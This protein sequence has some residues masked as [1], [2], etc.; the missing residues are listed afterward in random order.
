MKPV[1]Y[2]VRGKRFELLTTGWKPVMLPLNTNH[3]LFWR[4]TWVSIPLPLD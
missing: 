3:A 2:L 4:Y 1:A